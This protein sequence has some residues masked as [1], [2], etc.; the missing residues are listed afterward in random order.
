MT[1]SEP[2]WRDAVLCRRRVQASTARLGL[3]SLDLLGLHYQTPG[4]RSFVME[5]PNHTI[6]PFLRFDLW[7]FLDLSVF[8]DVSRILLKWFLGFLD[9]LLDV[10][11]Q[12]GNA[13]TG[14]LPLGTGHPAASLLRFPSYQLPAGFR[15]SGQGDT[16]SLFGTT[17][18]SFE[19]NACQ[20]QLPGCLGSPW[21]SFALR[22]FLN[23]SPKLSGF[24]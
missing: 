20:L 18:G 7:L 9:F 3:P 4:R 16:M 15:A 8:L 24:H 21:E 14:F 19:G 5:N 22:W 13:S 6:L 1:C 2:V 23:E 17:S 11:L 10:A 12:L